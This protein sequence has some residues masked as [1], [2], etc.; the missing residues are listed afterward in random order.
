MNIVTEMMQIDLLA[1][2]DNCWFCAMALTEYV[3]FTESS[4]T[5]VYMRNFIP[6]YINLVGYH[7]LL[8]FQNLLMLPWEYRWVEAY[9]KPLQNVK[10]RFKCFVYT[11][12][13]AMI[14]LGFKR[15]GQLGQRSNEREF[16]RW[17]LC[18]VSKASFKAS[19]FSFL[20]RM[21]KVDK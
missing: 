3:I 7:C 8:R 14:N 6:K 4:A 19:F 9:V 13:V 5:F 1:S 20:G 12:H 2:Y 15:T 11:H 21:E 16:W 17:C 10:D 18:F